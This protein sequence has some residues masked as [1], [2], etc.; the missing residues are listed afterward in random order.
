MRDR[1][2]IGDL[3]KYL[4]SDVTVSGWVDSRRDLKRMQF[5]VL[6][7]HTGM[8]QAVNEK[9][10]GHVEQSIYEASPES[11]V[12]ASGRLVPNQSVKLRNM[13]IQLT[14]VDVVNRA[15]SPLP[16]DANSGE[17][18]RLDW[19]FLDLRK[20]KNNLI[21]NVQT[22]AERAMREYWTNHGFL[23]MHSPKLV[24]GATESGA[25]LFQ[26]DYFGQ[27]ASLAQSPQFYKQMAMGAGFDRVFEI[28]PVFRANPSFTTRHDTEFTSVDV[29]LSWID[30][31]HDIMDLEQDW[32]CYVLAAVAERHGVDIKKYFG[33][34]V[35]VPELPFPRISMKEAYAILDKVGEGGYRD[36]K[37]D[38]APSGE[39]ALARYIKENFDHDF[40]FVTDYPVTARP[41]YHMRSESEPTTKS[42]DLIWKGLEVTTGAQREH[43]HDRLL[44][45]AEEKGVDPA[46]ISGYLDFFKY[47][48]PPHGG[49]GFGLTRMLMVLMDAPN[50][51]EVTYLYRGPKRLTP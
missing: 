35:K 3:E 38:L 10:G 8:V 6:R 1:N 22:T 11:A 48:M 23:E 30:S 24:P 14:D 47:G 26:L 34:D 50:V 36:E 5:L 18:A 16:I 12:I 19:R 40:V 41:F 43:R 37:G 2:L 44:A 27:K 28:A 21:F 42:F 49:Y 39:K 32:L 29:E 31:H 4:E 9:K 20:P 17:E 51:R 25:E 15:Q 46:A 7:D 45:Q 13:E 33:A